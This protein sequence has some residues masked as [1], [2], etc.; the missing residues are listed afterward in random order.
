M[1]QFES[2]GSPRVSAVSLFII[3]RERTYSLTDAFYGAIGEAN[4]YLSSAGGHPNACHSHRGPGTGTRLGSAHLL[5]GCP[6]RRCSAV[7]LN[8]IKLGRSYPLPCVFAEVFTLSVNL[9]DLTRR[10]IGLCSLTLPSSL[11]HQ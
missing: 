11:G 2:Y 5:I 6:K 4:G 8:M 7:C 10:K 3:I 9:L 1:A